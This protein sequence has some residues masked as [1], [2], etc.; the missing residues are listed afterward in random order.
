MRSIEEINHKIRRGKAVIDTADTF[1]ARVQGEGVQAAA[2]AVD[3]VV[4]STFEPME[5]S[6]AI[7]NLGHTDPPIKLLH[8]IWMECPPMPDL[9][10]WD[11]YLGASQP[12]LPSSARMG[13]MISRP[14]E[15]LDPEEI[16][17]AWRGPCHCRPDC[18]S[19]CSSQ[20]NWPCYR[21]AIPVPA[22]TLPSA[23]TPSNQFY[24]F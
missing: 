3:V 18:R 11:L 17:G 14:G 13:T 19:G 6:G 16:R 1:K 22:S 24:L 23:A 8:A 9:A 5:S 12:S 10:Q 2:R 21:T 20:G 15:L 4:T 7:L